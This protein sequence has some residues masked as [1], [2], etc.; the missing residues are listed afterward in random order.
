MNN[1]SLH[2]PRTGGLPKGLF[3]GMRSLASGQKR[4]AY[5]LGQTQA[6][7]QASPGRCPA[8]AWDTAGHCRPGGSSASPAP[9][10]LSGLL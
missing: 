7:P 10:L 3:L 9:G 4:F 6:S 8:Q 1:L 2:G 5:S